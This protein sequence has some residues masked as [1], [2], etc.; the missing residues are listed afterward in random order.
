MTWHS[1]CTCELGRNHLK[2]LW[3]SHYINHY[4]ASHFH[5]REKRMF[6]EMIKWGCNTNP[7]FLHKLLNRNFT[8][9]TLFLADISYCQDH[10][11]GFINHRL[12]RHLD[13]G[14]AFHHWNKQGCRQLADISRTA[15]PEP[16]LRFQ[17]AA[18]QHPASCGCS[19][20][21]AWQ[22]YSRKSVKFWL[23]G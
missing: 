7:Q 3:T 12:P 20:D 15:T 22:I 5:L 18:L 6:K 13:V 23:C 8:S 14:T 21:H 17:C 19:R 16:A 2:S 11:V 9:N 10:A 1:M 4:Q